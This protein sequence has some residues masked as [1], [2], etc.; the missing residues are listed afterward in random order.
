MVVFLLPV[1]MQTVSHINAGSTQSVPD[2]SITPGD[3]QKLTSISNP[4]KIATGGTLTA[5]PICLQPC[6]YVYGKQH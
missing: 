1:G 4:A 3:M 5:L 6:V 2:T